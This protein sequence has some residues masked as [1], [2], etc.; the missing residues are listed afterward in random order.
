RHQRRCR[1]MYGAIFRSSRDRTFKPANVSHIHTAF[2]LYITQFCAIAEG[3]R[4]NRSTGE[5]LIYGTDNRKIFTKGCGR[6]YRCSY[7][8]T[9]EKR[10][11]FGGN[12]ADGASVKDSRIPYN[13]TVEPQR[14]IE[15]LTHS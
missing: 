7:R 13:Q 4:I 1:A 6:T 10:I 9:G 15:R 12:L 11:N 3:N 5:R 8:P 14:S 2:E